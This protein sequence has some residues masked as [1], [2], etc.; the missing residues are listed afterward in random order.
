MTGEPCE[1]H[2]L[3]RNCELLS[4]NN[5]KPDP[6]SGQVPPAMPELCPKHKMGKRRTLQHIVLRRS[7]GT[8]FCD[9]G[10]QSTK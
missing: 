1:N 3:S 10:K 2:G 8:L 4:Y 5:G 7:C 9:E 6:R